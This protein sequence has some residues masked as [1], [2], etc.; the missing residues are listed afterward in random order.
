VVFP[1]K[2]IYIN[3]LEESPVPIVGKESECKSKLLYH[4][5]YIPSQPVFAVS[6]E[7][8]NILFPIESCKK[9]LCIK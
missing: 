2:S 5:I 1:P 9:S 6:M 3:Y 4:G 7:R 8:E